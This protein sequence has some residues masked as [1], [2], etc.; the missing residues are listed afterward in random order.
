MSLAC[1]Y[2]TLLDYPMSSVQ[3][4]SESRRTLVNLSP[5]KY[6]DPKEKHQFKKFLFKRKHGSSKETVSCWSEAKK[7]SITTSSMHRH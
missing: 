7:K 3:H 6:D 4:N 5:L 2:A 1:S